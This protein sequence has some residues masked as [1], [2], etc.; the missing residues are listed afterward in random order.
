MVLHSRPEEWVLASGDPDKK[1]CILDESRAIAVQSCHFGICNTPATFEK[2]IET[3]LR[4]LTY[5]SSL[6]Y[7]DDIIMSGRTLQ[8][9][10]RKL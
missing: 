5:E 10:L 2:L 8:D 7:L 6:V 1:D 3:V 4:G 9:H